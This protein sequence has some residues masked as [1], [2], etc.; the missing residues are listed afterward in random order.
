M[1]GRSIFISKNGLLRFTE[2]NFYLKPFS[3]FELSVG[4]FL[5]HT[6]NLVP[7]KI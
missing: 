5:W 2:V 4:I 1:F 6:R 7:K 3:V